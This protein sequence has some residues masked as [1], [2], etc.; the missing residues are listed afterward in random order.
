MSHGPGV[1][2]ERYVSFGT[3]IVVC[4]VPILP[5]LE[6]IVER[7]FAGRISCIRMNRAPRRSRTWGRTTVRQSLK[8]T[9]PF[10]QVSAWLANTLATN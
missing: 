5:A 10:V 7:S 4:D 2:H 3:R 8:Y 6:M 1:E 9:D